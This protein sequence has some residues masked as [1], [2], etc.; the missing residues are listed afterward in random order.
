M[1]N[2]KLL[3]HGRGE[4]EAALIVVEAENR[5]GGHAITSGGNVPLGGGT[6]VTL[7]GPQGDR[8]DLAMGDGR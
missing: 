7:A 6:P 4:I 3:E 1:F 5:I 8:L 2:A